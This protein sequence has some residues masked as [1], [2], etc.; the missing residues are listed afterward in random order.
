MEWLFEAAA[1]PVAD[2][3]TLEERLEHDNDNVIEINDNDEAID[4]NNDQNA[5][6]MM[7]LIIVS[8][9]SLPST[10]QFHH[11]YLLCLHQSVLMLEVSILYSSSNFIIPVR[12]SSKTS[13]RV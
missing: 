3:N 4:P 10:A 5:L 9:T 8:I 2:G 13:P 11:I 12:A 7:T 1:E 6:D